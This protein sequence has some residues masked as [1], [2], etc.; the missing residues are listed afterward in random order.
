M[1]KFQTIFLGVLYAATSVATAADQNTDISKLRGFDTTQQLRQQQ[2]QQNQAEKFQPKADVRLETQI[3]DT[4][5]LS[6]HESPCY[7]IHQITLI[8]YSPD[9]SLTTSQFQWAFEKAAKS[10]HLT[11]PHCFG[12]EGLAVLMKQIQNEI[13][14]KG[15]VTT[16]VVT[17]EQDLRGGKLV[18]TVI[19]G[20][21][22]NT[23][24]VDSGKVPRFTKLHALTGFTFAEGDI[25]NVRDIE[26]SLENLK[27][28]PTAEANIEILPSSSE[29]A[30]AGESDL[31]IS[32]SQAFPFRLN[33]GLDDAGSKSTG[34]LQTSATLSIDNIF[35][36]NDLFYTSFTHSMK[37]K[38]DDNGRRASK[39]L[40]LY[41]SVP[42]GYWQLAF[43]HTHSRYH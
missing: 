13:I 39:N 1:K 20:K 2:Y 16:R 34:K 32:Y 15:Y 11:L 27:R 8:D 12:G 24:V 19:P 31:K 4:L 5:T 40:T 14:G 9:N 6:N 43:S 23:L 33:L 37:Q 35:S 38:G 28:V 22:R 30:E 41:Y 10:L 18:L 21:I 25:L 42:F 17:S 29:K 7:P 26:Q 3:T 36:A